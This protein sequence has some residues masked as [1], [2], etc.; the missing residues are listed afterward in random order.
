M[1]LVIEPAEVLSLAVE[2][3][4]ALRPSRRVNMDRAP[5]E[6]LGL[7]AGEGGGGDEYG[8]VGWGG[9][10]GGEEMFQINLRRCCNEYPTMTR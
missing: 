3:V 2:L 10:G 8:Y 6:L 7:W 1:S 5:R 9:W 4:E